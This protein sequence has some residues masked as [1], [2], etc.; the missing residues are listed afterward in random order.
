MQTFNHASLSLQDIGM[1]YGQKIMVIN[2]AN[3]IY[4][5]EEAKDRGKGRN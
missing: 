2:V 3:E 1:H 5:S 4:T